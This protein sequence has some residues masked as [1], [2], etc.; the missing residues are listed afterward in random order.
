MNNNA[1]R[2]VT[3]TNTVL[4][5]IS[6]IVTIISI[7]VSSF[8]KDFSIQPTV[9]FRTFNIYYFI[10]V[11][12]IVNIILIFLT[13]RSFFIFKKPTKEKSKRKKWIVFLIVSIILF[14][15][16]L[17]LFVYYQRKVLDYSSIPFNRS[18]SVAY[19]YEFE[20]NDDFT[21]WVELPESKNFNKELSGDIKYT[22]KQSLMLDGSIKAYENDELPDLTP[23]EVDGNQL[24]VDGIPQWDKTKRQTFFK[25]VVDAFSK[26]F[27]GGN[28]VED[29]ATQLL[30]ASHEESDSD[31][32]F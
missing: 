12:V 25:G 20:N 7:A 26:S 11:F 17:S 15:L 29:G 19:K 14:V 5:S 32:P 8:F 13:I 18:G 23:I 21:K 31:L 3:I 28:S 24:V 10:A 1:A 22:G 2:R 27:D 9:S 16:M 6:I 4:T 30:T